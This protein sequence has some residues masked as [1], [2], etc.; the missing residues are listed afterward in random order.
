MK[1]Q[2][3]DISDLLEDKEFY[4]NQKMQRT[5]SVNF[6]E[7]DNDVSTPMEE[8]IRSQIDSSSS[9]FSIIA[10]ELSFQHSSQ[11]SKYS[12][13][14]N[15]TISK[16]LFK[17]SSNGEFYTNSLADVVGP[18]SDVYEY[19]REEEY[20]EPIL[21]K[22]LVSIYL[23]DHTMQE[24]IDLTHHDFKIFANKIGLDKVYDLNARIF[25]EI[26]DEKQIS[27]RTQGSTIKLID[28]SI[29]PTSDG[30]VT[31]HGMKESLYKYISETTMIDQR[32]L[33]RDYPLKFLCLYY[34][35]NH[36]TNFYMDLRIAYQWYRNSD[37]KKLHTNIY[38]LRLLDIIINGYESFGKD[39][40][41]STLD[42]R[43]YKSVGNNVIE[44]VHLNEIEGQISYID[45]LDLYE[46]DKKILPE[47]EKL[48][49][50]VKQKY[51]IEL[52]NLIA[53][54]L[55]EHMIEYQDYMIGV[56]DDPISK[57]L[58]T[59]TEL[60]KLIADYAFSSLG[61]S[62]NLKTLTFEEGTH[63]NKEIYTEIDVYSDEVLNVVP[64]ELH[65]T[66]ERLVYLM[67]KFLM[68]NPED[69]YKKSLVRMYKKYI[70]LNHDLSKFLFTI[71][72][73]YYEYNSLPANTHKFKMSN[74]W[75]L[76]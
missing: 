48:Q 60:Y 70:I 22:A 44:I 26:E 51:E 9:K 27:I 67:Y 41:Y 65:I 14:S 42:H 17:D 71:E 23:E 46:F 21:V 72:S 57:L 74:G 24:L 47:A 16:D 3:L 76:D 66:N 18:A 29:S 15:S 56:E 75:V 61:K 6:I 43:F 25:N 20:I 63:E 35:L 5:S 64:K 4:E 58:L 38:E 32:T 49:K 30:I 68:E 40:L 45:N 52:P 31:L 33:Q 34:R 2:N 7:D 37:V 36:I 12:Q 13:I 11:I 50:E 73:N 53:R 28:E 55:I 62:L 8:K 19:I 54:A 39:I 1:I 59:K 69:K 10:D